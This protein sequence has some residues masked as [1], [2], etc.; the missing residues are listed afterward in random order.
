MK[1][2]KLFSLFMFVLVTCSAASGHFQEQTVTLHLERSDVGSLFR[3]I[4]RQTGLRF[5]YNE[6]HV[7]AFP[8]FDLKR[9][10]ALV[11][12]VLDEVFQSS[13][14]EWNRE[15]DVIFVIPRAQTRPQITAIAS[16]RV[17]GTVRDDRGLPLP[18]VNILVAGTQTGYV[19]AA[20]GNFQFFVPVRDTLT[21]VFS[22]VGMET[23]RVLLKKLKD[24][25]TRRPLNITMRE[26]RVTLEDF[27]VTGYANIRKSSFTG[28]ATRITREELQKITTGNVLQALQVF[29]PS[30]RTV[31]N[32]EMGSDPNTLPEF[33]IRGA[34][35]VG[36]PELDR[37][38]SADVSQFALKNNPNLP[39]FILD[40]YEVTTEKIYDMDPN[41]IETITILKDAA[42]TAMYGSR[43]ANGVIVIETTVPQPGQLRVTYNL[44]GSITAPDLTSYDLMN[45]REKLDAEVAAGLL[46]PRS[47]YYQYLAEFR[48]KEN[49]INRGV[50]TYWLSQPLR[51]PLSH[52]HSLHV[53]GGAES[54]R[55]GLG[56]NYDTDPGVMKG[57]YR[58][59]VGVDLRVDYRLKGLQVTDNA[60]FA[61]M[62]SQ[63]SPYGVFSTYV[64]LAPYLPPYNLETGEVGQYNYVGNTG[65]PNPLYNPTYSHNFTRGGY[66]Q[67]ANNLSVN[68][69]FLNY[70]QLKFQFSTTY[71]V[72]TNQQFIDPTD[73]RY[74]VYTPAA[75][76]G[77]LR[78]NES[79]SLTWNTNLM[80]MYNRDIRGDHNLNLNLA[81][82]ANEEAI[83]SSAFAYS[84]F[85]SGQF[86]HPKN[87]NN[88]ISKPTF[89]DDNSRLAG[90]FL[91]GNYTFRNTYLFDIS[92]RADGSSK[93]GSKQRFAP[94]WS[95][96]AGINLHQYDFMKKLPA[97]N[98]ARLKAN[99][100]QT[101]RVSFSP[102]AARDTYQIMMDDW[103]TTGAGGSLMA[104]G[105]EQLSWDNVNTLNLGL[106]LSLWNRLTLN[107]SWYDKRTRDMVTN[108][109]IPSSSGFTSYMDNMGE[110]SNKG[111]EIMLN[112]AIVKGKDWNVNLSA[113]GAHNKNEI[114]KISEALKEYNDRVDDYYSTYRESLLA[115]YDN[116][117]FLSP[118]RKYEEGGS[119]YA[120]F[121]MKSLGISPENGAEL[122][123][124]RDGTVTYDWDAAEQI[125]IGN[126]EPTLQGSFAINA[127]YKG[128]SLYTTFLYEFGGDL[129]NETLISNVE[130]VD[131]T[132]NNADRRAFIQRWQKPGDM[133]PF[134]SITDRY[135]FTRP[136][137][138]FVQENNNLTFNSLS[139]AYDMDN[140]LVRRAGFSMIRFQFTMNEIA[141]LSSIR[142]ERGTSYPFARKFGFTLNASF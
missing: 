12:A 141:V 46:G 95:F 55:F 115:L 79:K 119:E 5:V 17:A 104:M 23:Q 30:L 68:A 100:G 109:T 11:S 137:S 122:F 129:Y 130:S 77:E 85:P 98:N 65:Y 47:S 93:F 69:F 75:S 139:L 41:R 49:Y 86:H 56:L 3:E 125:I 107:L 36:I 73:S 44:T 106:D 126:T 63:E 51:T 83:N 87:A 7:R 31:R 62:K 132:R 43:A 96:G 13:P 90:I 127:R 21:L 138:R 58:D 26:D 142:Q 48:A 84:G 32:N 33:N 18:G 120:I 82:N 94:F 91:M 14:L 103:Y 71:K 131:I 74:S 27:V 38:Q 76:R 19:T 78:V 134:K 24:G 25:E 81:L 42:A 88:L 39:V 123:M 2:V 4:R 140:N 10:N 61:S 50:N 59:R 102:Y 1:R 128:F 37:V 28:T 66:L 45:A 80:L 105:N 136:T 15:E 135:A 99:Y 114:V 8:R 72:N 124:N 22:F 34:A 116:V 67:F 108:V 92:V 54:T 110:V 111:Y 29:D 121:G 118:I 40:G 16:E 101:G 133:A 112:L 70:F 113:N 20:D 53:E 64:Q 9:E 89:G 6:R 97:I 117:K 60:S 57:S 52:R 35:G